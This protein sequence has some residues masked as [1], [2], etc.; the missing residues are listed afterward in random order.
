MPYNIVG[1]DIFQL[2]D[3]LMHPY[4][5]TRSGKLPIDQAVFIYRVRRSRRV[6]ENFFGILVARWTLFR[7]PIRDKENITSYILAR[8]LYTVI[9]NREKMHLIVHVDLWILKPTESFDQEN[10]GEQFTVMLDVSCRVGDIEDLAMKIM[11]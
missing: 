6:T 8:L 10:G 7:K 3:Y 1:D 5:G 9:F 2:K 4:P 11:P